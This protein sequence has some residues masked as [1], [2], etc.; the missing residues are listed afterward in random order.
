MRA[1]LDRRRHPDLGGAASR[2]HGG[3][4]Q[5]SLHRRR[6]RLRHQ[7]Q[8]RR[9]R[10]RRRRAGP[11][12]RPHPSTTSR[13]SARC[14]SS[15]VR[16][17]TPPTGGSSPPTTST[18]AAPD[19]APEIDDA[20]AAAATMMIY[21]SGTTGKPKGAVRRIAPRRPAGG[22]GVR[23][24]RR[25]HHRRRVRHDRSAV[26]QR[27]ARLHE[28]RPRARA[29]GRRAAQVRRRGLAAARRDVPLHVD[30]L[31]ADADADDL[32]PARRRAAALRPVVDAHHDRQRRAV[33]HGTQASVPRR[34]PAGLA[35]R[36]VRLDRAERQHDPAAS[37]S[38]AQARV[39]RQGAA[40]GGDPPLRR[41]RQHRHGRRAGGDGRAVRAQ[42]C[43][44]RGLLQAARQVRRRPPR[45]VPDRRRRRVSRRG[46]IPLHLRSQARHDHLR[47]RQH[48]SGRESRRPSSCTRRSTRPPCS[49]SPTR[50]G[51]R[52]CTPWSC[53]DPARRS[54][55]ATTSRSSSTTPASTSP[56]SRC[57]AR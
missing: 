21:T 24:A 42:L 16:A 51:A 18:A 54:R 34:V 19:T 57:R 5:L 11:D 32:Q 4:R 52:R 44:V 40:D 12:V 55:P 10:V 36:G 9:R 25:L 14:S 33:E 46:G 41:R 39:V 50:S 27:T 48:L 20:A 7:P 26:P 47:R 35:V 49:A 31:R 3:A 45:R 1:E 28:P 6:G 53:P 56:V 23:R 15:T 8:R 17:P 43:G 22:R 38:A 37:R 2:R 13:L 30:V 29:D